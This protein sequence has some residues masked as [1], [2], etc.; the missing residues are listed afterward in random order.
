MIAALGPLLQQ[1]ATGRHHMG[2]P[3]LTMMKACLVL[4]LQQGIGVFGMLINFPV[5]LGLTPLT[6]AP[7]EAVRQMIDTI[8]EPEGAGPARTIEP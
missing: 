7:S 5:P 4:A 3:N 6:R 8:H 1:L 2:Q